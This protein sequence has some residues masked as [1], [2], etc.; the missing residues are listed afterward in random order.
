LTRFTVHRY[1]NFTKL[2]AAVCHHSTAADLLRVR[3][4]DQFKADC[5]AGDQCVTPS[6]AATDTTDTEDET[7]QADRHW[8]RSQGGD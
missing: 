8:V 7:H 2:I 4:A 3:L 5:T 1:F 6:P